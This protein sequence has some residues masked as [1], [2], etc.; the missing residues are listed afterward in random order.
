MSKF[1]LDRS[2]DLSSTVFRCAGW[3]VDPE[4]NTA[5]FDGQ[6][7]RLG[8][9]LISLWQTL[10]SRSGRLVSKDELIETAWHGRCVSDDAVTVAVYELRK[11][12]GDRARSPQFIETIP[13]KGYRWLTQVVFE[14]DVEASDST[15]GDAAEGCGVEPVEDATANEVVK[16]GMTESPHGDPPRSELASMPPPSVAARPSS[17]WLPRLLISVLLMWGLAAAAQ[18]RWGASPSVERM[19]LAAALDAHLRG[20]ALMRQSPPENLQ[21]ALDEFRVATEHAP[22]HGPSWAAMAEVCALLHEYGLGDSADLLARTDATARH[23]LI[24][25]PNH[26]GANYAMGLVEM[27]RFQNWQE[28]E[29]HFERAARLEPTFG[30]AWQGLG[31]MRLARGDLAAA[32]KAAE[33]AALLEPRSGHQVHLRVTVFFASEQ[34][35]EALRVLDEA[36]ELGVEMTYDL[37][38]LRLGVLQ[39]AGTAE[40]LWPTYHRLLVALGYSAGYIEELTEIY[41]TTGF[42]GV[43]AHR[44]AT[45]PEMPLLWRA[46]QAKWLGRDDEALEALEEGVRRQPPEMLVVGVHPAFRAF[47]GQPRFESLL[48]HLKI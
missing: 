46:A 27:L 33:R 24:L 36:E 22:D 13:G 40:S 23:A 14:P 1:S 44:L 41:A 17:P 10:A 5:T 37:L 48:R 3:R 18:Q 42:E 43:M 9:T 35:S 20:L 25:E 34:W 47:H 7:R 30:R 26:A 32:A 45:V 16:H 2:T 6:V 38:G 28:A 21:Q 4:L 39:H 19:V 15:D 8:P 12:L 29:E 11:L 31:W